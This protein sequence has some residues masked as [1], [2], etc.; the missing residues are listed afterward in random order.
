MS[1]K[2]GGV[3]SRILKRY[4][5]DAMGSMAYG[6]FASLIIGTIIGQIG[7]LSG[8]QMLSDIA[9]TLKSNQVYGAAIGVAIA[10]GLKCDGLVIFAA[11]GSA[12]IGCVAG[13]P[14]GAY[15]GGIIG[16]ELGQLVSKKT[17]VDIIVTPFVS[18]VAG[19]AAGLLVG[20][21]INKLMLWLGE[22]INAAVEL[23][24][25]PMGTLV[26]VIVGM[27]L[28]LPISSAALCVM[29]GL[30]GLAAGAAAAGCAAQMIGF[31]VTSFKANRVSGLISQGVGTSM[32]Q[33]P[34][35]FRHPQIWIA[36]TVASA[37]CGAVSAAVL[38]IECTKLG[39]G[40]GTSGLVGPID[41]YSVM[42]P[43]W[44]VAKTLI[45]I[46]LVHF[47]L[48]AA[49]ALL[50]HFALC[51]ANVVKDEYLKLENI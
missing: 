42:A 6:L 35:I 47:V 4:F 41:T 25:L 20:P 32:L 43:Q 16:A 9:A 36:P 37:V 21:Y 51:K 39:A 22:I 7:T 10:W 13:G 38:K 50:V 19:G 11:A 48:P 33:V 14:V 24:P 18:V 44:G 2:Q 34:N 1:K 12:A 28:T 26:G 17:P 49:V 29:L 23:M 3:I 30:D 5:I 15:I 40:M 8:L 27:I 45:C 46:A 31:A